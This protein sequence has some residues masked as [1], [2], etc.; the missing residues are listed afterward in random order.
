MADGVLFRPV[1]TSRTGVSGIQ[2]D[3]LQPISRVD[4]ENVLSAYGQRVFGN[5]RHVV[6]VVADFLKLSVDA[7]IGYVVLKGGIRIAVAGVQREVG[8]N[9][10]SQGQFGAEAA[11]FACIHRFA[12]QAACSCKA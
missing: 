5:E 10:G 7:G 8:S 9:G 11:A 12:S 3:A 6:A 2:L 1:H 4:A